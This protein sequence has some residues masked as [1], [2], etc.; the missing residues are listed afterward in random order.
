MRRVFLSALI[1]VLAGGADVAAGNRHGAAPIA[2]AVPYANANVIERMID[3]G[4]D[5]TQP[6]DRGQ[7]PLQKG[8]RNGRPA[9]DL[10]A[11][12]VDA[13]AVHLLGGGVLTDEN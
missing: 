13:G 11:I 7:A 8:A 1:L 9:A 3:A 2:T 6:D 12:L 10:I 4:I 5:P